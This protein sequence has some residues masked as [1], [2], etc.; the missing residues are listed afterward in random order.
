M[1]AYERFIEYVKIKSPSYEDVG[2]IPS[3]EGQ[4]KLAEILVEELRAL[5]VADVKVDEHAYVYAKLSPSPGFES[6]PSIGF[7]S[8]LD[9]L[10]TY[11][12]D[13]ICPVI[14]ENYQG[15]AIRLNDRITLD[16]K[17]FSDLADEAHKGKTLITTNGN[18]LLGG[19][20]KAGM[21]EI[22]TAIEEIITGDIKHPGICVA[23]IPDQNVD[24]LKYFNI[25]DFSAD[26]AY[27]FDG[28]DL[29]D[30]EYDN[31]NAAK[32]EIS[33]RGITVHT[34]EAKNI[35]KNAAKI[36]AELAGMLP[37]LSSPEHTEGYEGFFHLAKISGDIVSSHLTVLIRDHDNDLF[38][39]KK[40]YLR[41]LCQYINDK[42]GE[43]TASLHIENQ[44][45]NMLSAIK[46]KMFLI[47]NARIAFEKAGIVPSE[48]PVR[49][50][51]L[52]SKLSFMGIPCPNIGSGGNCFHGPYEYIFAEDMDKMVSVILNL[53]TQ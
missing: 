41:R 52:G 21:A 3:S 6:K 30:L 32:A 42:H 46:D 4:R 26:Y 2:K 38:E 23:F 19:D 27:T 22:I 40:D 39:D 14:H 18:T 49:G 31:F 36:A 44:Y 25:L 29:G 13:E 53:V 15:Q 20:G 51:T 11:V 16:P 24:M 37:R 17:V 50:G 45:K 35:M 8:H 1:R 34:G 47:K 33:I 48:K 12:E 5:G 28:G 7:I 10:A 43:K 9:T